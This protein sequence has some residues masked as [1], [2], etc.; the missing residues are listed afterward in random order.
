M[1]ENPQ[2]SMLLPF[3]IA[4]NGQKTLFRKKLGHKNKFSLIPTTVEDVKETTLK[5]WFVPSRDEKVNEYIFW[6][7][8]CPNVRDK[9]KSD[10]HGNSAAS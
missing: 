4:K 5:K 10:K 9:A 7:L 3:Y 6:S 2:F 1:A 8:W